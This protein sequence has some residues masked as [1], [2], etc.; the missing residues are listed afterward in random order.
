[1]SL[2]VSY[3]ISGLA[4][5]ATTVQIVIIH[6]TRIFQRDFASVIGILGISLGGL[7]TATSFMPPGAAVQL[8]ILGILVF[9]VALICLRELRRPSGS[10]IKLLAFLPALIS[11]VVFFVNT[12]MNSELSTAHLIARTTAV[13]ALVLLGLLVTSGR[14]F[15]SDFCNLFV[16]S[17][18][19]ILV[20]SFGSQGLWRPCDQ[21]KCGP[22]NAIYTGSF[23]SENM[24]GQLAVVGLLFSLSAW[25]KGR[26][27]VGIITLALALYATESRT[28]QIAMG[29]A[30]LTWV[31]ANY[32]Q[33]KHRSS[34]GR[35]RA[36]TSLE[37][38]NLLML[39]IPTFATAVVFSI[40]FYLLYTA[41]PT[42]LSNRGNVWIRGLNA[43]DDSW[44][45]GLGIDRWSVLQGLGVVPQLY[46]HSE[47]L[48]MLF[49][50]GLVGVGLI[51]V[52]FVAT[53]RSAWRN[54][55]NYAFGVTYVMLLAVVGLTEIIWNPIT[56]DISTL[57]IVP[58]IFILAQRVDTV[59][60]RIRTS[61]VA[62]NQR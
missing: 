21:F 7:L 27:I 31:V 25:F 30:L 33:R 52:L 53:L 39:V 28:S 44:M 6:R 34:L 59:G 13:A 3:L 24:L 16:L 9:S 35:Q 37:F 10:P 17:L 29:V 43:L 15:L 49:S 18:L 36:N 47:Y 56:I 58:I 4:L 50:A 20:A 57:L 5:I 60:Q 32:V 41:T 38:R 54:G 48:F 26:N 22:F 55:S 11:M 45:L 61:V 1:M 19:L 40:G 12:F 42:S 8:A 62:P 14:L 23:A 51:F 2:M 46:P